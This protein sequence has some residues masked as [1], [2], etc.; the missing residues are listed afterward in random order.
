MIRHR[1][2]VAYIL[3]SSYDEDGY[4]RRYLRGIFPSNTLGCLTTLTESLNGSGLLAPDTDIEVRCYDDTLESP[5][6]RQLASEADANTTVLIG[7]A[8]V[9]SCQFAR[10]TDLAFQCR[11]LGMP[12]LVGGFHVSGSLAMLDRTPF[13]LQR[14]TDAGVSLISGEAESPNALAAIFNDARAG[15]LQPVYTMPTAPCL[16]PAPLP[17]T[18]GKYKR[19]FFSGRVAPLDTSRGCPFNCSFCTVINVLGRSM[20]HRPVDS[21]LAEVER[22]YD[23][24][25]RMWFFVDDNLARSPIWEELFDGLITIRKRYPKITFIMQVDTLAYKLPN[26]ADK[27]RDAGCIA[28]FIGMESIDP[29]NL[30]E[31]GKRQNHVDDYAHMVETWHKAGI[32]VEVGYITGM[33]HD[34]PESIDDAVTTLIEKVGVDLVAFFMLTPLPGSK[35][36]QKLINDGTILDADLNNYDSIHT[37]FR[38]KR[39]TGTDWDAAYRRAWERFYCTENITRV[40]LRAPKRVYWS[41]FWM[42]LWYRHAVLSQEHPMFSGYVRSKKRTERRPELQRESIPRFLLRRLGDSCRGIGRSIQLY[43]EFQEIWLITRKRDDPR[44]QTLADLRYRLAMATR[45]LDAAVDPLMTAMRQGVRDTLSAVDG[46]RQR[47]RRRALRA[48]RSL[49]AWKLAA[50]KSAP[51]VSALREHALHAYESVVCRDISLRRRLTAQWCQL[52]SE[53]RRGLPSLRRLAWTPINITLELVMGLRFVTAFIFK[54][55]V[56]G[57]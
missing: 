38:H 33:G 4:P 49:H 10:A 37:T 53:L 27:A 35:D 22:A 45:Q 29:D 7:L 43:F 9:Q 3:C 36:H 25:I 6:I 34:T 51:N 21:I 23:E 15:Q 24:G 5:P 52:G 39:M 11:D 41:I 8:G 48:L 20:R 55:P 17:R 16:T 2:I 12:V 42:M 54:P 1:L 47:T 30:K 50:S 56:P 46:S 19:R 26:F 28:A 18:T 13:E 32:F 14:L 31:V 40:L 57:N 44:R